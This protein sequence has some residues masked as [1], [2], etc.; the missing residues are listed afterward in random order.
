MPALGADRLHRTELGP[1]TP[2]LKGLGPTNQRPVIGNLYGANFPLLELPIVCVVV[3]EPVP[4]L[5]SIRLLP[6]LGDVTPARP[7]S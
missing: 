3:D 2:T 5:P 1:A 6:C 4:S 7:G